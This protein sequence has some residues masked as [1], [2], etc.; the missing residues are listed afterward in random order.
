MA[1]FIQ[2]TKQYFQEVRSEVSKV[3]WP[4]RKEVIFLSI[5]ILLASTIVALFLGGLDVIF[6]DI[7][8]RVV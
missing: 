6:Q 2:T 4:A 3:E 8:K 7:L 5:V 1:T